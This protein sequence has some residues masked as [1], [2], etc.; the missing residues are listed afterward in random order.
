MT[1][2]YAVIGNPIA[3]SKSPQIHA[4][5]AKATGQDMEY[6]ALLAPLQEFRATV[7]KFCAQGG[8]GVNVTVPFKL[9]ALH[10]ATTLSPQAKNAEA[11]NTLRFD[12]DSSI[13]GHNTDGIGLIRDIQK[14]W[15]FAIKGLRVL[16]MG[17]GGAARGVAAPLVEEQPECLVI[18]NRS[19]DKVHQLI[20]HLQQHTFTGATTLLASPYEQLGGRQFDLI[21]NA[22]ASSLNDTLPPVP[23]GVFGSV[24]FAYDMMYG[25]GLT[26]FL[27]F[28]QQHGAGIL[29]DG[30]GMLVEQA[31]ESFYLWRGVRPATEP[32]IALLKNASA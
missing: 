29:A 9:E 22:T 1:D 12:S 31:A 17:A 19:L 32:V 14:N 3:H 10:I 25:R 2:R 26:P 13:L 30:L 4:E 5:F 8:K 15:G 16:L 20:K 21:I 28:A 24:S 23:G 27:Q 18:A 7:E 6:S 11:V